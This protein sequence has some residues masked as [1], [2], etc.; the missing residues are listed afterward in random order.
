MNNGF[1]TQFTIDFYNKEIH[2]ILEYGAILY[3]HGLP[4]T[5]SDRVESIQCH[6]FKFQS[7]H[8]G[9][10]LS[11]SKVSIY[12]FEEPLSLRMHDLCLKFIK[13]S[14]K[15]K[16]HNNSFVTRVTQEYCLDREYSTLQQLPLAA[17]QVS[18]C[19]TIEDC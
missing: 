5:L 14:F 13:K 10:E 12:F 19:C 1:E 9:Q 15:S 7:S 2:S 16:L 3:H 8:I 6:F 11:Y 18:T 17:F 4:Q